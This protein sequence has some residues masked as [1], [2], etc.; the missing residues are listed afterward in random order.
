MLYAS[1]TNTL[2]KLADV[3]TGSVL[4]SGGVGVAPAYTSTP[5]VT[6]V[7]YKTISTINFTGGAGPII[8]GNQ[9]QT[10]ISQV[11]PTDNRIILPTGATIGTTYQI[12]NKSGSA[13]SVVHATDG[14]G[15]T[16]GAM[17]YTVI[18]CTAT[19]NTNTDYT[20]ILV[21]L[22]AQNGLNP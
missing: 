2:S 6:S 20:R 4:A 1:A 10:I 15:Y 5:T 3:A 17:T 8:A 22:A 16:L 18:A 14:L 21:A 7:A 12:W 11:A 19:T 13:I 9:S